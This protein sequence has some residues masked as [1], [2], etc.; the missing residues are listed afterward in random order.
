MTSFEG[1]TFM[2]R[3]LNK[4]LLFQYKSEKKAMYKG[5]STQKNLNYNAWNGRTIL[6]RGRDAEKVDGRVWN[7]RKSYKKIQ[8]KTGF[9]VES[10][11]CGD[12]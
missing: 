11:V 7:L 6:Q 12:L 3:Q 10:R 9:T 2:W 4:L 1:E 5:Y 8:K